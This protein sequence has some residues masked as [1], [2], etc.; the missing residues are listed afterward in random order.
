MPFTSIYSPYTYT[1]LC[2]VLA[3][4]LLDVAENSRARDIDEV[5]ED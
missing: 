2:T 5:Q 1:T 3:S 4:K